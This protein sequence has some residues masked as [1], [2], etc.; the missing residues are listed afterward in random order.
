MDPDSA[1]RYILA[2]LC[3]YMGKMVIDGLRARSIAAN[4]FATTG[5][6]TLSTATTEVTIPAIATIVGL[7]YREIEPRIVPDA[8]PGEAG[9][10]ATE[11]RRS[12]EYRQIDFASHFRQLETTYRAVERR[13]ECEVRLVNCIRRQAIAALIAFFA[14]TVILVDLIVDMPINIPDFAFG[15]L[16]SVAATALIWAFIEYVPRSSFEGDDSAK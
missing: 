15:V 2:A 6:Q 16:V 11:W 4:K 14:V 10:P 13:R 1:T 12:L 9:H 7:T 3:V 8:G 5:A